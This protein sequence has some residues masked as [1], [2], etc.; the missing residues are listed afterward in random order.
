MQLTDGKKVVELTKEEM[1][2]ILDGIR[3]VKINMIWGNT[4]KYTKL[5][6]KLRGLEY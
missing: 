4:E 5:M 3:E 2:I 6:E 1:E